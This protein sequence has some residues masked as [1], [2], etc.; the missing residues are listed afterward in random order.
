MS[1]QTTDANF[2]KALNLGPEDLNREPPKE[3]DYESLCWEL[4]TLLDR[5]ECEYDDTLASQRFDILENYGLVPEFGEPV[6]ARQQ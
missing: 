4:V 2:P 1:G 3:I 6:S 5:I